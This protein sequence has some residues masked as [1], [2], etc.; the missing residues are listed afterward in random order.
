[1]EGSCEHDNE[2]SGFIRCWEVLEWLHNWQLL[3]KGS[4]SCVSKYST[5]Y[6]PAL[7]P[8]QAPIH[9][10]TGTLSPGIKQ[11]ESEADHSPPSSTKAEN[12]GAISPIPATR[13][14]GMVLN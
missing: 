12:V 1:V 13:L 6:I 11:P 4:E 9:Q 10:V 2:T 8:T 5:A 14:H 3:K 7:Q